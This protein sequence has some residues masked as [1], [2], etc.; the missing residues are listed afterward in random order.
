MQS[1]VVLTRPPASR[2]T[3]ADLVHTTLLDW[4]VQLSCLLARLSCVVHVRSSCALAVPGP[5][6]RFSPAGCSL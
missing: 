3:V 6:Q 1:Q 5:F 2:S 4:P